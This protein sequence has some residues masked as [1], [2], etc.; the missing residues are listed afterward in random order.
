MYSSQI[1]NDENS[2]ARGHEYN[3]TLICS[4]M[5]QSALFKIWRKIKAH[6]FGAKRAAQQDLLDVVL[7]Q[8]YQT[9]LIRIRDDFE[10]NVEIKVIL[11]K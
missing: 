5:R 9:I 10:K 1:G 7:Y 2:S 3:F 4:M 11:I 8:I 6:Y